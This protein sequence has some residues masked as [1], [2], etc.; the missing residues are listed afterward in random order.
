LRGKIVLSLA[1]T[2]IL[3]IGVFSS[4]SVYGAAKLPDDLP[5]VSK[6]PFKT[7]VIE[8]NGLVAIARALYTTVDNP[9]NHETPSGDPFDGVGKLI[10]TWTDSRVVGCTGALLPTGMHVLT[11]AHCVTDGSGNLILESGTVTFEGD[12]DD[13]TINI[14]VSSTSVHPSWDGN[15]I[16]GNDIAVLKLANAAPDEITK[17]DIDRN[18]RDDVGTTVTKAGYGLSGFGTI[19]VDRDAFPFGMKRDG[20]NLYDATADTMLK[21]LGLKSGR[22]FVRGSVL[23]YDFDNGNSA[24]DAFGFFFGISDLGEGIDEVSAA[25]GDSGGPSLNG[26]ITGITS[27]GITLRF[28]GG[29]TSD[30]TPNDLDSSFGEFVGDTRVSK[31]ASFIDEVIGTGGN[32]DQ[33]GDKCPP[34]K[35]RKGLC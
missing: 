10:L 32:G 35:H 31:H 16:R 15:F 17:L 34:G 33:P 28:V 21:A 20:L 23:Q 4:T 5:D 24:N 27:Y 18:K 13:V 22:D 7:R 19:G 25:P 30:V 11:A 3:V 14:D 29:G 9:D 12:D 26:V 6:A 1:I 8:G 2:A